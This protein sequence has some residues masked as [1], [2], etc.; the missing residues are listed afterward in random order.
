VEDQPLGHGKGKL[1]YQI[2]AHDKRKNGKTANR[3]AAETAGSAGA[4]ASPVVG[5]VSKTL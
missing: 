3:F 2:Q 1:N 4:R 5:Q